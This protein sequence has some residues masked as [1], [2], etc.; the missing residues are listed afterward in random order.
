MFYLNEESRLK[1]AKL[2]TKNKIENQMQLIREHRRKN[3]DYDWVI[4]N[5]G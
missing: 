5:P 1:M 2:I 4:L 3:P